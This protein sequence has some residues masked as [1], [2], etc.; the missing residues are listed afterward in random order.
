MLLQ[1]MA[2]HAFCGCRQP[3]GHEQVPPQDSG[4]KQLFL[5][6]TSAFLPPDVPLFQL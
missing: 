2:L 1:A 4:C 6:P 5:V 3:W